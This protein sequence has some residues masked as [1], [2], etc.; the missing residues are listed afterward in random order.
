MIF[1]R[2][3]S[4]TNLSHGTPMPRHMYAISHKLKNMNNNFFKKQNTRM[5][6]LLQNLLRSFLFFIVHHPPKAFGFGRGAMFF[7]RFIFL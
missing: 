4:C 7:V 1:P 2:K 3:P 5:K 6:D